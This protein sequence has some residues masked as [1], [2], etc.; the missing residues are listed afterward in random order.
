MI[1]AC[2]IDNNY[3]RH[4]AVMLRSLYEA[5]AE[6]DICVYIIHGEIGASD[7]DKLAA[8]LGKFL[9]SVNFIRINP[10][11]LKGFPA[12]GHLP[13][14]TYYR[15]LLSAALPANIGQVL[16]L[17]CDLIVVDSL[18]GLWNTSL[19]D[20]PVAAVTDHHVEENCMRLGLSGCSG[21]F[22]P[23]VMLVDL[24]K[25][26]KRELIA[27]G[28]EFAKGKQKEE[29]KHCDQDILNYL[30]RAQ[31]LHL[32]PKWNAC[33]H[34]WG[35]CRVPLTP[36][37]IAARDKPAIIRFAG[38]GTAKPWNYR[39]GHPWKKRYLELK[40]KTPWA[41]APLDFQPSPLHMALWRRLIGRFKLLVK[42]AL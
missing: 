22:N 11:T 4:C 39:C 18:R 10:E 17:D 21:Y 37:D 33:P 23:G 28:L 1:I 41:R 12:Y 40:N 5:N 42:D 14:S 16:F 15:L 26:R 8:Y 36:Q 27:Q 6:E 38:S 20:Y 35:L 7:K 34:L 31:W 30:F 24:D 9:T 29:L 2:A 3:I 19:G 25:W 32:D 13:V